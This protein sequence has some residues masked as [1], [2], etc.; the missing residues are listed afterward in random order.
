MKRLHKIRC[1]AKDVREWAEN[2]AFEND[3][4]DDLC[5]VCAIASGELWRRLADARIKSQIYRDYEHSHC[6]IVC[7]NHIVDV[8][9]SQFGQENIVIKHVNDRTDKEINYYWNMAKFYNTVK[10]F[11]IYQTKVK[12]AKEQRAL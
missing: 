10:D 5:G 8:T 9:A 3:F 6:F 2:Y 12:W 1:I 11:K 4:P 7:D